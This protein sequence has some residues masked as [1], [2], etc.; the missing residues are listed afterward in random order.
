MR[1]RSCKDLGRNVEKLVEKNSWTRQILELQGFK[2]LLSYVEETVLD[3]GLSIKVV[4]Q[5]TELS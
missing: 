5:G 2:D 3:T 4:I 1:R